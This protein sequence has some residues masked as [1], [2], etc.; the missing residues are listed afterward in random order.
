MQFAFRPVIDADYAWLWSLKRLTMQPYVEQ[1]WGGWDDTAQEEF[2]RQNFIPANLR[3]ITTGGRDA[4]L[5]HVEREARE[6]FLANIQ[7]LPE[8]QNRGLGSAVVRDVLEDARAS[9]LTVR[10]QVLKTNPAARRLY[11]R[12]GFVV[13]DLTGT[14]CHMRAVPSRPGSPL[15]AT[16]SE[17]D[18]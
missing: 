14:H 6:F 18:R 13:F 5:L 8:F 17:R 2:F 4:G 12:L 3:V 10:L 9:G 1:T 16:R 15:T 11:E 7:I